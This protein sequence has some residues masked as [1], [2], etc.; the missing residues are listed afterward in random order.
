MLAATAGLLAGY[1]AV[2]VNPALPFNPY[3]PATASLPLVTSRPW[4]GTPLSPS[5]TPTPEHV[6]WHTPTPLQ[7]AA[8][9]PTVSP[10]M[11]FTAT[12]EL[13][14]GPDCRQTHLAGSVVDS[15][16]QPLEGYVVHI[17]GPG[18]DAVVAAGRVTLDAARWEISVPGNPTGGTWYVQLHRHS[19]VRSHPAVS[20]ILSVEL[21]GGC[22][23]NLAL[24]RFAQRPE[25]SRLEGGSE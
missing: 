3:P 9:S 23:E 17:W 10:G 22:E 6:R 19:V 4:Q 21:P 12:I 11:P 15:T 8:P 13:R 24:I 7:P 14:A 2:A 5:P 16:G 1:V 18:T 20:P 25:E